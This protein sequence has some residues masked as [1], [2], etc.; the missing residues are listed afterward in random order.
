MRVIVFGATGGTGKEVISQG[1]EAGY[2][3]TAFVHSLRN[4]PAKHTHLQ[5]VQGDAL[6]LQGVADAIQGQDAVVSA[7]GVKTS[8]ALHDPDIAISTATGNIIKSMQQHH[9]RRLL[10]VSSFGVDE[11][12]FLPEKLLLHTW[13]KNLFKDIPA[14]EALIHQSNLDWT[15]VRPARLTSGPRTGKYKAGEHIRINPFSHISRSDVADYIIRS[16]PNPATIR[17]TPTLSY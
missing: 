16:L 11:D 4:S 7:L 3:M 1:L 6:N 9:V 8:K 5:I 15:I 13:L 12:V 2:F 10:F 14:Q 17:Q